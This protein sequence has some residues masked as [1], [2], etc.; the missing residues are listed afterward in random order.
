MLKR[1]KIHKSC[2]F[3][4]HL[5]QKFVKSRQNRLRDTATGM[6]AWPGITLVVLVKGKWLFLDDIAAKTGFMV[7]EK[8]ERAF[9]G[10]FYAARFLLNERDFCF[11]GEAIAEPK[12]Q[13]SSSFKRNQAA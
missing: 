2:P 9:Q 13:K 12:N 5:V 3:L 7:T 8:G 10:T 4:L 1:A 11:F 6:R